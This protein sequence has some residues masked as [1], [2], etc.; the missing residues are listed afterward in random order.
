MTRTVAA[1]PV[2]L[3]GPTLHT[4][5]VA[6]VIAIRTTGRN[7]RAI[8]FGQWLRRDWRR[9]GAWRFNHV[10]VL[11][12]GGELVEACPGRD[13]A[14]L[15]P[16]EDYAGYTLVV[17]DPTQYPVAVRDE[18]ALA[19]LQCV[20]TP[21]GWPDIAALAVALLFGAD[22]VPGFVWRRLS[23]PDR[24]VCSQLAAYV[25]AVAGVELVPGEPTAE[26]TPA[27]VA[28]AILTGRN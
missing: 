27:A 9:S 11:T 24:L 3:D 26:V 4:L 17:S 22:L 12:G 15:N 19:A 18:V 23:R 1:R 16:A 8:Q 5:P 25:Y 13:G 21:Y 6:T 2:T 28:H 7:A 20:G 10:A 14:E